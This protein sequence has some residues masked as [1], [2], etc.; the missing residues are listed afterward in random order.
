MHEPYTVNLQP[1]TISGTV[2]DY[3]TKWNGEKTNSMI[4]KFL[5]KA[6]LIIEPHPTLKRSRLHIKPYNTLPGLLCSI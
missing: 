2:S 6:E 4:D 3:S 5:L 1:T